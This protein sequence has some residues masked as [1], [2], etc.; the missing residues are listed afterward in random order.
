MDPAISAKIPAALSLAFCLAAE[1]NF[2]GIAI[3]NTARQ[4]VVVTHPVCDADAVPKGV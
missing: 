4:S 1:K 2:P 3:H